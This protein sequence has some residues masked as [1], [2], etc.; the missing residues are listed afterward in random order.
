MAALDRAL[1]DD[2]QVEIDEDG[3]LRL[4][5]PEEDEEPPSPEET[6]VGRM[7]APRITDVDIP[8]LL[9]DINHLTG[10]MG[11][12]T[13]AAGGETRTAEIERHIYATLIAHAC[14]HPSSSMAKACGL[15]KAKL[16]YADHWYFREETLVPANAA[17]VDFIFNHPLAQLIGDGSFSSSDGRRV[18][19]TARGSQ[20]AKALPRYFGLGRGVTFYTWTSDQHSHYA[21][22]VVRTSLRDATYVLDGILDNQTELPISKHTTDTAGYSDLIFA[23]FDLLELD[24]CPHLAGLP[25]RRLYHLPGMPHDTAAGR[26]LDH[27]INTQLIAEYWDELLRIAASI[28]HGHVTASLLV[29]RLQA[30]PNRSQLARALQEYGRIIKTRFIVRYHTRPEERK[31]IRRQLNKHESMHALHDF[32]FFGNDGKLRLATLDRQSVRAACLHL[33]AN[34]VVAWNLVAAHHAL[35]QL[36]AEGKPVPPELQR[37]FSPTL[38]AHI[39]K[40]G[41][42]HIDPSRGSLLRDLIERGE[43]AAGADFH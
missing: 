32:L 35:V 7:L 11:V 4:L 8:D 6:P 36:E 26:L 16:D 30:H 18:Q 17:I 21:S 22:R 13:H 20:H 24:F 28:K 33:V 2:P 34:A 19:V 12:F 5:D 1:R 31:A 29:Q 41:K 42:F 14:N 38:N 27:P 25:D 9:V 39:N 10:F 40:I 43:V 15:T 37:Q 3:Q 23:L